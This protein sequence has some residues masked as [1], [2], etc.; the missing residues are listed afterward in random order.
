MD[1][2]IG[3]RVRLARD[4]KITGVLYAGPNEWRGRKKSIIIAGWTPMEVFETDLL[5]LEKKPPD[6]FTIFHPDV[7]RLVYLMIESNYQI[8]PSSLIG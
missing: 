2:E 4:H 7:D 5:L 1:I 6:Q 8:P 3:D